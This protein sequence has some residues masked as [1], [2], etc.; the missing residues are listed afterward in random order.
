M[1]RVTKKVS[2]VLAKK[3]PKNLLK[4]HPKRKEASS[5][6]VR[7][8]KLEGRIEMP[9][10]KDKLVGGK[11][12]SGKWETDPRK[13]DKEQNKENEE[14]R[15]EAELRK[16]PGT[17]EWK[18]SEEE[19]IP[20]PFITE[21]P[22]PFAAAFAVPSEQEV[23]EP[24]MTVEEQAAQGIPIDNRAAKDTTRNNRLFHEQALQNIDDAAGHP[25]PNRVGNELTRMENAV[26]ADFGQ[27]IA[28][29]TFLNTPEVQ[30]KL[31]DDQ[32]KKLNSLLVT[33]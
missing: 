23:L 25:E 12:Q 30:D 10:E 32:K 33:P 1:A 13:S 11:L 27:I 7:I 6:E 28:L 15:K 17:K 8:S 18:E 26:I 16:T 19:Q 5:R 22:S 31:D 24:T 9:E 4:Q 3:L 20:H 14:K 21:R 2:R 29:Q